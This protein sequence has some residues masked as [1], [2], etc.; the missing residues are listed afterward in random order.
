[1]EEGVIPSN[2]QQAFMAPERQLKEAMALT[3]GMIT[4]IDD[5]IGDILATLEASGMADDTII[6][7]NSDHGDYM[8]AFSLLLKGPF[9]H[10]S[11]NRVPFIWVDPAN[12]G[13]ET[14]DGLAASID[15]G[16]TLLERCGLLP[17][18]GMQGKSF[19]GQLKGGPSA[20]DWV[21]IEHEE[22]KVYPGLEKRP[23][24]RNLVTPSHRMTVYKGLEFGELYDLR[25]DPNETRN[26]WDEDSAAG[27]KAEMMIA[28]NQ[29][30]LEAIEQGP[31]PTRFA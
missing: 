14:A 16:P 8:G 29:A 4:M 22:N 3:A 19:L 7:F 26:L 1:M 17:Y 23:N 2:L 10:V 9:S 31:W 21:L 6:I 13:P 30:M 28:L 18:Y 24:M 25:E 5:A 15:I 20:R 27:D 11:V 12:K